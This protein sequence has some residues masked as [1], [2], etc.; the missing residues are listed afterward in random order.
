[1]AMNPEVTGYI[2]NISQ[3]WQVEVAN[4]LREL[5]HRAIPDA[6]ERIQYK[7]PHFLKDGH[8]AAVISPAK[9][10]LSF[11][12]FNAQH[13]QPPADLFEEGPAERRTIKIRDDRPVDYDL[14]ETLLAQAASTL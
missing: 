14:L 12:I 7:K 2:E 9:A 5:V 10:H 11:T 13:L 4:A 3:P 1:M 8:Y 6:Q